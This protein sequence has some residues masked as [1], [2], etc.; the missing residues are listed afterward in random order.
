MEKS[1]PVSNNGRVLP[2]LVAA[3]LV[4]LVLML[5]AIVNAPTMGGPRV[6]ASPA[7]YLAEVRKTAIPFLLGVGAGALILAAIV[8]RMV[9]RTWPNP[10]RRQNLITGYAFLAPYLLITSVFTIGVILFAFAISFT[11]YDIFTPPQ[12]VGLDNYAKAFEGFVDPTRR[13]FLQSLYNVLWYTLIVV[14]M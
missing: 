7:T 8:F 10:Q 4:F 14:P 2:A 6:M 12:F 3:L 13:Q 5:I 1:A 9:Y 11:S